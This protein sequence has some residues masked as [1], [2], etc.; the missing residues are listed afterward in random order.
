M[1]LQERKAAFTVLGSRIGQIDP[2]QLNYLV[3]AA[4]AANG[5]FTEDQIRMAFDGIVKMLQPEQL[6]QWLRDWEESVSPSKEIGV[7]MA[8]NIPLVGFHD[9]LSVLISGHRLLAKL[10]AQDQVLMNY[11]IEELRQIEPRFSIKTPEKLTEADAFIA[12]GSD[13]TARYFHYYFGKKPNI[14]RKNR[15]S[16][17]IL[18]GEET[19]E[20]LSALARDI[21]SYYGLGC[22]NVSKIYY[23]DHL[24]LN[25]VISHFD[26]HRAIAN[27]HKYRNNYDYNKSILLVNRVAHKDNGEPVY[28]ARGITKEQDGTVILTAVPQSSTAHRTPFDSY[29]CK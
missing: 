24:N 23:P 27:H 16:V 10:S 8:G 17:A 6:D 21:F 29:K 12:T 14:I 20:E 11:I 19:P 28:I 3:N 25:D 13:N 2:S 5:W 9:L 7:V 1:N 15:T 4:R 26:E 18:T 22:R